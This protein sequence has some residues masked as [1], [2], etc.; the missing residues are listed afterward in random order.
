MFQAHLVDALVHRRDELDERNLLAIEDLEGLGEH[1]QGDRPAVPDVLA[2]DER[3]LL[4]LISHAHVVIPLGDTDG[5]VAQC[6]GADVDAPIEQPRLLLG[7]EG[8]VI[9]DDVPYSIGHSV[10]LSAEA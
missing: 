7:C 3:V 8:T 4:E 5:E 1:D 10:L 6:V 9:P 2:V